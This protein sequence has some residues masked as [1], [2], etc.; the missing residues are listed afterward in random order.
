MN[1][2]SLQESKAN[3]AIQNVIAREQSEA[4]QSK[5]SLRATRRNLLLD[6]YDP[7]ESRN[8]HTKIPQRH[9]LKL[10]RYLKW[11]MLIHCC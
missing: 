2:L 5:L 3:M 7:V 11:Q 8:N 6:Y 1:V 4:S 9:Q 10:P